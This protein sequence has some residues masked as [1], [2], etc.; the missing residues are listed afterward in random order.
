VRMRAG[1]G[2]RRPD[3][4]EARLPRC[5]VGVDE[6]PRSYDLDGA[7][8]R[9]AKQ[10]FVATDDGLAAAGQSA[11]DEPVVV[12]IAAHGLFEV[13]RLAVLTVESDE[14]QDGRGVYRRVRPTE[15]VGGIEVLVEDLSR[16][17]EARGT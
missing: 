6:E 16:E 11:G 12:G 15:L 13:L 9:D 8:P 7:I 14:R 3:S 4:V 10:I 1:R 2:E 17:Y 5:E